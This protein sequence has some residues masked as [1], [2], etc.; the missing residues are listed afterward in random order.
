[1]P[2]SVQEYKRGQIYVIGRHSEEQ[3]EAGD[4]VETIINEICVDPVHG[5]GRKTVKKVHCNN[6][7]P[8]WA[9]GICPSIY[10]LETAYNY[11]PYTITEYSC[12]WLSGLKIL[13]ETRYED[14]DGNNNNFSMSKISKSHPKEYRQ[15]EVVHL[16]LATDKVAD[17][18]YK[19]SE[20]CTKLLSVKT[21][22]GKL[23]PNWK[24]TSTPLM[25]SYKLVLVQFNFW[26]MQTKVENYV[27]GFISETLL[28]A[29]GQAVAWLDSW[30]D[31]TL[32]EVRDYEL[33]IQ[34]RTNAKVRAGKLAKDP[35]PNSSQAARVN[36]SA[37]GVNK[38][39]GATKSD[40]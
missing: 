6:K 35:P 34:K 5:T 22:R 39:Q 8:R 26:C 7:L 29:H 38:T 36:Q 18:H 37:T 12:P 16:D 3:S 19:A 33:K 24:K 11:Y 4:G 21:G 31:M 25:C 1:M 15:R 30:Y 27:H 17:K 10:I 23:K 40:T 20:D 14:N 2:L 9:K 28:L 13:I 32:E